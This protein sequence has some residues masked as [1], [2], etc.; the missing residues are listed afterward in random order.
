[1]PKWKNRIVG[2]AEID[3]AELVPN[4]LNW[5]THPDAQRS[6]IAAVLGDVGW[7]GRILINKTTG[8]MLDGRSSLGALR[9]W[10]QPVRIL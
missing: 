7:V 5:R 8:H 6:G 9:C 3:P 10:N 2:E 4:P 1:M